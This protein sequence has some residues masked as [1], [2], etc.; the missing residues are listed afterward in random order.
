[1]IPTSRRRLF[2]LLAANAT[3]ILL[4][5]VLVARVL[6]DSRDLHRQRALDAV[7]SLAASLA[8][9][10]AAELAAVDLSLRQLRIAAERGG[11][12]ETA[13]SI[14]DLGRI[15][16]TAEQLRTAA[17]SALD[18]ALRDDAALVQGVRGTREVLPG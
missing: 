11:V 5:A 3:V 1:M 7:D 15:V 10:V 18:P 16:P 17:L 9:N 6:G 4:V 14:N 13:Q 2:W 12:S 8:N